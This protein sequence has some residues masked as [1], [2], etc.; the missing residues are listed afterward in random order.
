VI[1]M[2]ADQRREFISA[3]GVATRP[4]ATPGLLHVMPRSATA[5]YRDG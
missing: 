5:A 1:E 4:L 3:W 2:R